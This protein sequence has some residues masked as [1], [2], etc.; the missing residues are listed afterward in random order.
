MKFCVLAL[1][2]TAD[3]RPLEMAVHGRII[4]VSGDPRSGK[5][6]V[7]GLFCEQLILQGYCLC[8]VDPEGDYGPLEALPGVV[9]FG[10]DEPPP[11]LSDV[12]RALRY[13][14]LSVV[15]DLSQS[16]HEEKVNYL[17]DLLPM[18]AAL[19]RDTG[20][21]H[22]IVVDEAHY[23]L[24]RSDFRRHVDIELA[25]YVL[26]TYRVSDLPPDLLKQVESI[27]LT[28]ITNPHEMHVLT[29]SYGRSGEQ[30]QAEQLLRGLATDE[31]VFVPQVGSSERRLQRFK[32]APRLTSHVRHRAKYLEVP[33]PKHHAFFFTCHGNPIGSPARTLKQ[34]VTMLGKLPADSLAGHARRSDFSRWITDVIGD[35]PLSAELRKVEQLYRRGE[36]TNLPDSLIAPIRERYELESTRLPTGGASTPAPITSAIKSP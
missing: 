13:P 22:W 11:R 8:I 1:D 25:G 4:L 20:Q 19:R 21:P 27:I 35:Y 15:I 36:V 5:S 2:Y 24:N 6:W 14:D 30:S 31:A 33:K 23:F 26:V 10:R 29:T 9:V 3:G 12:A 18:V 17:K 28:Q 7:T 16:T 34:F 32:I